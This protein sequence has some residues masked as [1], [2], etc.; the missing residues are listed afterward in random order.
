MAYFTQFPKIQYDVNGDGITTTMTD[1][2]KR[3]RLKDFVK[4]NFVAFDF[5]D[6]Q[7]GETPEYLA[8]EIYGD[9]ELHWLIIL[10][11]DIIDYYADWPMTT[12]Q[13]EAYVKSKYDDVNAIHHYEYVQ[14]SGSTKFTIELPNESATTI[15][16]GA[17][18]ITN[19]QYE[20]SIQDTKRRIR[21]VK[22][23]YIETIK[24]QFKNLMN[25]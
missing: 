6:V 16:A 12:P 15:P 10:T 1:I 11:N 19:Y 5:Y 21:I 17:L 25:G 13:F 14:N 8:N 23:L 24:K 18:A 22:P 9:P 4:K 20:E 7:S 3:I 2:T